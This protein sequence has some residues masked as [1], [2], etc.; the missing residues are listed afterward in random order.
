MP[1][2]SPRARPSAARPEAKRSTSAANRAQVQCTPCSRNTTAGRSGQRAGASASRPGTVVVDSGA[3]AEPQ[4]CDRPSTGA[5]PGHAAVDALMFP[6][7]AD[8]RRSPGGGPDRAVSGGGDRRRPCTF[9]DGPPAGSDAS[10]HDAPT[11]RPAAAAISIADATAAAQGHRGCGLRREGSTRRRQAARTLERGFQ[12]RPLANNAST[13]PQ[14]SFSTDESRVD[15]SGRG[16]TRQ[17]ASSR[18]DLDGMEG[19]EVEQTSR[20]ADEHRPRR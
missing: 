3:L 9:P 7:P 20:R 11:Q 15:L 16:D 12:Q 1:S 18:D 4:T 17:G 14:E 6:S 19:L 2:R 10:R 5:M 8:R 13:E